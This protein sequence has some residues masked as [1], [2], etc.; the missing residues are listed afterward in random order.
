MSELATWENFS[1]ILNRKLGNN[2]IN[3]LV[4]NH[5]IE[6]TLSLLSDEA[7]L[8]DNAFSKDVCQEINNKSN[9]KNYLNQIKS[10]NFSIA[11]I[12]S[13]DLKVFKLSD[14]FYNISI[15][16]KCFLKDD[17]KIT[18]FKLKLGT[19]GDN[20]SYIINTINFYPLEIEEVDNSI[21]NGGLISFS[22][23][24]AFTIEFIS[25]ELLSFLGFEHKGEAISDLDGKLSSALRLGDKNSLINTINDSIESK[26]FFQTSLSIRNSAGIYV[27]IDIMGQPLMIEENKY[28][29]F[30]IISE[31][32]FDLKVEYFSDNVSSQLISLAQSYHYPV[33]W[34][35]TLGN[36][37]GCNVAYL[38]QFHINSVKDILFND[39]SE[40][41]GKETVKRHIKSNSEFIKS[42][43][44]QITLSES[45]KIDDEMIYIK[46]TKVPLYKKGHIVGIIG[47]VIDVTKEEKLKKTIIQKE[48]ELDYVFSLSNHG[49][50]IKDSDLKFVK[51]NKVFCDIVG[52]SM[53]ELVGKSNDELLLDGSQ[54]LEFESQ[55]LKTKGSVTFTYTRTINAISKYYR[56]TENPLLD[57]NNDVIRIIGNVVD[58]TESVNR[59]NQLTEDYNRVISSLN[60]KHNVS[61]MNIDMTTGKVASFMQRGNTNNIVGLTYSKELLKFNVNKF[62]YK[63]EEEDFIKTFC[64][65][66]LVALNDSKEEVQK[67]YTIVR[68][69]NSL[70]KVVFSADFNVNPFT[71]HNEATLKSTDITDFQYA[72]EIVDKFANREFDF[73][74]R[75]STLVDT[76]VVVY[77]DK[78]QYDFE[79]TTNNRLNKYEDNNVGKF[80]DTL[81]RNSL[82]KKPSTEE[83]IKTLN[84][85]FSKEDE[86]NYTI[87]TKDGRRKN[88]IARPLNSNKQ[89]LI[90][91]SQDI[92]ERTRQDQETKMK[93]A[94]LADEAVAANAIKTDFLA[95]MSHD[96]RTPLTAIMGL[97]DFGIKE[98]K[99]EVL[100][101][102]FEKIKNSSEYLKTLLNDVLDMQVIEKGD[103]VLKPSCTKIQERLEN[104]KTIIFPRAK[105]KN[106]KIEVRKFNESPKYIIVDAQRVE[107]ILI[108]IL[109][110]ALKYTPQNGHIFWSIEFFDGENTYVRHTI[111]DDGVGM[112]KQFQEH[113]FESFS[114]ED[115]IFS[116]AEGGSGLGLAIVKHILKAMNGK[117]NCTSELGKG[118]TFQIDIPVQIISKEEYD[119]CVYNNNKFNSNLLMNKKILICEDNPINVLILKK[120]LGEFN[121]EV[122]IAENGYQGVELAQSNKYDAILMDIRM[123]IMN[124]LDAAKAIRVSDKKIPIIAIS[125]NAYQ[126]DID[127]SVSYG[128][129]AHISKPINKEELFY[130]LSQLLD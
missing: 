101:D 105:D 57:D 48:D 126:K 35:D 65:D 13:R 115:N 5:N 99:D 118:T 130:T 122:E 18:I 111:S 109:T 88:I 93:L 38:E 81:Y 114:R 112:T 52:I 87:D 36:F 60:K 94:K 22:F 24:N 79:I 121:I 19:S 49:Y 8:L 84:E 107:Q 45:M 33:F 129:N 12:K 41:F 47:I 32:G 70:I 51:V 62:L 55:L 10:N 100:T 11:R 15:T 110:N 20:N 116:S 29:V 89:S 71:L 34:K 92:T 117:I 73:I 128:M 50:F 31:K 53:D 46:V 69:D 30:A 83:W 77:S 90:I 104:I 23:N 14:N 108:N 75:L 76:F 21:M 97:T 2:F 124:G 98:S 58:I 61:F 17:N 3:E 27:D 4:V 7:I 40:I 119:K 25:A 43:R 37:L 82:C 6:A 123:P 78:E 120:L 39:G 28:E 1:R 63:K 127:Q 113:M 68:F 86:W 96:M 42:K 95:R 54:A 56:V 44:N 16:L 67:L 64:F 85:Y 125:A 106:I 102:Y 80:L 66:A 103:L 9:I 26:T 72:R 59:S 91:V 74:V